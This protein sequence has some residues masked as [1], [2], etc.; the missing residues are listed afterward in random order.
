MWSLKKYSICEKR[1]E[2]HDNGIKLVI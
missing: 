1:K 2:G